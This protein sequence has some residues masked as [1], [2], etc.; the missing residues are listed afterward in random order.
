MGVHVSLYLDYS[1]KYGIGYVLSNGTS[2][3]YFND[4]T[5][6]LKPAWNKRELV[7]FYKHTQ[8]DGTRTYKSMTVDPEAYPPEINKKAQLF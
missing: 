8:Q 7:Y 2:G 3:L 5:Y 1:S 6:M 4:N